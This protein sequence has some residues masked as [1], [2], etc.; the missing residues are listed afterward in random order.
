MDLL[1]KRTLVSTLCAL[2]ACVPELDTDESAVGAPR[3]LAIQATPAESAPGQQQ[4]IRYQAL[5]ADQGGVRVDAALSWFHCLAQKPLAELGPVS[6]DCLNINSGKLTQIGL[7]AD[8]ESKLPSNACSLFGPNPPMPMMGQPPGRPV[9]PD[10][11]GG[12]KLPVV[13]AMGTEAG[14]EVVLYE[15]R[16][17]CGLANVAPAVSLEF[18]QRYHENQ[19]PAVRELRVARASGSQVLAEN[20]LLEVSVGERVEL[21]LAWADC[22]AVDAC[23]DG[24][25]G[26]DESGQLCAADCAPLRGC[27]GQERYL[28]YDRENAELTVRREALRVAWYATAGHFDDERTGVAADEQTRGSKNVWQAPSVAGSFALWTVLRDSRGG[29]GFRQISVLVR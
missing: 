27:G 15:Q 4:P 5:V 18:A 9:D 22:P 21:E 28:D 11:S 19:N 29:V 25:C 10:E 12:Y 13:V 3:V 6:R 17:A 26:P 23:G 1:S 7:G 24:V 16:I 8:I 20:V 14:G 2:S